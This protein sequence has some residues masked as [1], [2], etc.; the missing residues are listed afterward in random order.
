MGLPPVRMRTWI[1]MAVV[2][3][4]TLSLAWR[5][6]TIS[7]E[8][9]ML[10]SDRVAS[11]MYL[12]VVSRPI[13]AYAERYRRPPY[14]LD[15]VL[16]HLDSSERATMHRALSYLSGFSYGWSWCGYVLGVLTA[17]PP[18]SIPNRFSAPDHR[19]YYNP[20]S[21]REEYRWPFGVGRANH[22]YDTP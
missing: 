16:V 2:A 14:A 6:R 4:G 1:G 9:R 17:P 15:S 12:R 11:L 21:I 13:F 8:P 7:Q 19:R 18:D 3:A 20:P 10:V 22:C 5:L